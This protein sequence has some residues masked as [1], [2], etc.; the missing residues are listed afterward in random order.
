MY[1]VNCLLPNDRN[2]FIKDKIVL[3]YDTISDRNDNSNSRIITI[4][5]VTL[6]DH[7]QIKKEVSIDEFSSIFNFIY[8][9]KLV[10]LHEKDFRLIPFLSYEV[11]EL[12]HSSDEQ[13]IECLST[14]VFTKIREGF[15]FEHLSIQYVSSCVGYGLFSLVDIEVG[16]FIGE[17]TGLV[18]SSSPTTNE[19]LND[20][21][22]QYPILDGGFQIDAKEYGNITRFINHSD[23]DNSMFVPVND[24]SL[25]HIICVR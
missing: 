24:D 17:Y 5:T 14:E 19:Q 22:I 3:Y 9:T 18:Y 23:E 2:L 15:E 10:F 21:A 8:S 12:V 20:Y 4:K 11:N 1:F 25:P 16:T 6:V 7:D 13:L